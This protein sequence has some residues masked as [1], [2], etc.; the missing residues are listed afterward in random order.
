MSEGKPHTQDYYIKDTKT[1]FKYI[2]NSPAMK[3][4]QDMPSFTMGK[5]V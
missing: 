1:I 2:I 5:G 3:I 4:W